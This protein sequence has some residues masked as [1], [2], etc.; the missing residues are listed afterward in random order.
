MRVELENGAWAELKDPAL[1]TNGERKKAVAAWASGGGS[2]MSDFDAFDE[3]LTACI[4]E[5]SFPLPIPR[6][7]RSSLD[8]IP[9]ADANAL[10]DVMRPVV[11]EVFPNF[12]PDPS[13]KVLTANSSG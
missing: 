6:A 1:I 7:D 3:L 13:P 10:Y 9:I 8:E 12:A 2:K 11:R 5:W 4:V